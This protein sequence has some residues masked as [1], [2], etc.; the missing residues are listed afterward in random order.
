M[1]NFISKLFLLLGIIC[2]VGC[3]NI[4]LDNSKTTENSNTE[5]GTLIINKNANRALDVAAI[6]Y[7]KVTIIGSDISYEI[8]KMSDKVLNGKGSFEIQGIPVGNNRVVVVDAYANSDER[9]NGITITA[10]T[11]IVPGDNVL[12]EI[13]PISSELSPLTVILSSSCI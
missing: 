5:V 4:S 3:S 2:V 12:D 7:A 11:D 1:K 6:E 8:S 13:N 10:V 9:M